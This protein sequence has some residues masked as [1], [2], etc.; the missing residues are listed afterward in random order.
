M[1]YYEA[2]ESAIKISPKTVVWTIIFIAVL[3]VILNVYYGKFPIVVTG[4]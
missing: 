2:E 3:V 4:Q 1:R